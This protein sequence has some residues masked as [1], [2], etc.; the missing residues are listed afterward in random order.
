MLRSEVLEELL[1]HE[2]WLR[3]L[4]RG[5]V[6]DEQAAEDALQETWLRALELRPGGMRAPRAWLAA[7]ARRVASEGRRSERA[8]ALREKLLAEARPEAVDERELAERL[9]TAAAVQRRLAEAVL[10]LGEPARS[11]VVL[12]YFEG[13]SAAEIA[14]A[15]G[16]PESTVRNRIQRALNELRERLDRESGGDRTRWLAALAP[17]A[18]LSRPPIT[19]LPLGRAALWVMTRSIE[20]G[21]LAT[22]G[23]LV[24]LVLLLPE[25]VEP[26]PERAVAPASEALPE[27]GFAGAEQSAPLGERSLAATEQSAPATAPDRAPPAAPIQPLAAGFLEVLVLRAGAAPDGSRD[28]PVSE[29]R[30]WLGI[31]H[32]FLPRE[33]ALEHGTLLV[34]Q[35]DP[36][37]TARFHSVPAGRYSIGIEL[38][39]GAM[40]QAFLHVR[41]DQGT[42]HRIRIGSGGV[43][44]TVH[45]LEGGPAEGARVQLETFGGSESSLHCITW[46]DP[47]GR[48][49]AS[50]LPARRYRVSVD[51]SGTQNALGS[52]YGA[53]VELSG[54]ELV[55][56]DFG[57]PDG[58][59]LWKGRVLTRSGSPAQQA[60]LT[61]LSGMIHLTR[62]E[63]RQYSNHGWNEDG[64]F[65]IRL[66]PGVYEVALSPPGRRDRTLVPQSLVIE[67]RGSHPGVAL[68]RDLILPGATV[69]GAVAGT[70]WVGVR[71]EPEH[72]PLVFARPSAELRF[73]FDGIAPGTWWLS[74]GER[75]L[76]FV[77]REEDHLIELDLR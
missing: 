3:G 57:E 31:D 51:L 18:D 22:V 19:A 52:D 38:T 44:G 14:R 33:P 46:T 29:G 12:R 21:V 43:H 9:E 23:A 20:L 35:L 41:D 66:R 37:G 30:V 24:T 70:E 6:G 69:T 7:V 13:R 25:A 11:A 73:R 56:L 47:E 60:V 65:E 58:F 62:A 39:T 2:G 5:L 36:T 4:V 76:R 77:V 55:E 63:P 61:G 26:R 74:S 64:S 45:L 67:A 71:A 28:E 68:E 42:R 16:V 72:P 1:R 27:R 75:L 17:L 8:R 59:P 50:H 53:F 40:V 34:E 10:A 32:A 54:S 49:A 15:A 48:Y